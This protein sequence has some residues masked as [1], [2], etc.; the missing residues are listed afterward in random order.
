MISTN[1][2]SPYQEYLK[3]QLIETLIAIIT[4]KKDLKRFKKALKNLQ[5][6]Y[7]DATARDEMIEVLKK[8]KLEI[9]RYP[10]N[11]TPL[12]TPQ[13]NHGIEPDL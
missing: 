7:K 13:S 8:Y 4:D 12:A 2:Y 10:R 1:A 6:N 11:P 3:N 9:A 5:S